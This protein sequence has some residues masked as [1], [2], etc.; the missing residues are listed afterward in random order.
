MNVDKY[1]E[2]LTWKVLKR[3]RKN[4]KK[5]AQ[6]GEA[7]GKGRWQQTIQSKEKIFL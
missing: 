6:C 4:F 3:R 7:W 1:D 5:H 2:S